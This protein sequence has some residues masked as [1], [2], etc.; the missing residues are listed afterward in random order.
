MEFE[1]LGKFRI[2]LHQCVY[3]NKELMGMFEDKLKN[4]AG[5]DIR[6]INFNPEGGKVSI[7]IDTTQKD[8]KVELNKFYELFYS[9]I[10]SKEIMELVFNTLGAYDH[11][12]LYS[13][14]L[15]N[16]ANL[17]VLFNATYISATSINDTLLINL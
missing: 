9:F 3:S 2:T 7:I 13:Y 15:L 10:H 5:F 6:D 12:M 1:L 17:Q 8:S 11:S 16:I 14:D 4:E